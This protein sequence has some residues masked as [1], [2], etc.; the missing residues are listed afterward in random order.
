MG[1]DGR[2]SWPFLDHSGAVPN[3]QQ[4]DQFMHEDWSTGLHNFLTIFFRFLLLHLSQ[5]YSDSCQTLDNWS[6]RWEL[7][8]AQFWTWVFLTF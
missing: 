5:S 1:S 2:W 3:L 4:L 7:V 6:I 8:K